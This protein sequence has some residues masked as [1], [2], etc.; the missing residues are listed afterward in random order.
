MP[1]VLQLAEERLVL[2]VPRA[3]HNELRAR[4]GIQN[5]PDNPRDEVDPLCAQPAAISRQ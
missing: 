5:M 4:M 2:A 3:Q 1:L